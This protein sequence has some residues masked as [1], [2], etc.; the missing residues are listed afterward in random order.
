MSTTP[1]WPAASS[2]PPAGGEPPA[3]VLKPLSAQEAGGGASEQDIF[4]AEAF[5]QS[6]A[7]SRQ[8]ERASRLE[9]LVGGTFLYDNLALATASFDGY[10]AAGAF[11]GKAFVR[12]TVPSYGSLYLSYIFQHTLYQGDGGGLDTGASPAMGADLFENTYALSEFYLSFD[13]AEKVFSGWAINSWPGVLPS[14]RRRWT[15]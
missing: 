10:T 4:S 9:Y 6:V 14:S 7:E 12:L 5:D 1:R 2:C 8:Q 15:S 13:L 3:A 11:S